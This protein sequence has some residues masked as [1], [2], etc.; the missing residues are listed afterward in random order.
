MDVGDERADV[1]RILRDHAPAIAVL[2]RAHD[3][4]DPRRPLVPVTLVDAIVGA[5]VRRAD[6]GVRQQ[7]LADGGIEGEA[8]HA[9]P[10]RVHEHRART[11]QDV[12]GGDLRSALLE[13]VGERAR[14]LLGGAAAMDGENRADR[15]VDTDVG[16]AVERIVHQDV[17]AAATI[18]SHLYRNR[19]LDKYVLMY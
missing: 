19:V 10:R 8:V 11:V 6:V 15:D 17:L 3:A 13:T 7:K 2:E 1:P 9:L 5:D 14:A 4:L 18:V 16:R 12:A